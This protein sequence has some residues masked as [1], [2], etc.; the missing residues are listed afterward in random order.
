MNLCHEF[1]DLDCHR[2]VEF[3]LIDEEGLPYKACDC[4]PSCNHIRYDFVYFVDRFKPQTADLPPASLAIYFSHDEFYAIKR[5][6]GS[7]A[8]GFLANIGGI[9]GLFLG[10]SLMT[11]IDVIYFFTLRFINNLL[12][13]E[14]N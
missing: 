11:V 7:E 10:I 9:L 6:A 8:I 2:D 13:S 12:I 1:D 3:S 5:S 4:L 14:S